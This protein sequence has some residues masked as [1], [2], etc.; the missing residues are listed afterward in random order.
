[1]EMTN[2]QILEATFAQMPNEFTSNEFTKKLR[3]NRYDNKWI[4]NHD[5]T[6]YLHTHALQLSHRRW[7][8]L[9]VR[10]DTNVTIDTIQ[11]AI[12]LLKSQGYKVMKQVSE[13][14]EV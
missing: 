5:N 10:I 8:K 13:Y 4:I 12:E 3:K 6:R 1:M 14:R 2:L 7:K 9:D 11:E